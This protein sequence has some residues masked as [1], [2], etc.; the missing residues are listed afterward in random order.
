MDFFTVPTAIF[1]VLYVFVILAHDRRRIVH[2]NVTDS[3]SANWTALQLLHAFP[4]N[5]APR[6]LLRDRDGTYGAEFVRRAKVMGIEE[7]L[8]APRSPWQK[9]DAS[10]YTSFVRFGETS[11]GRLRSESLRPCCLVGAS[12]AGLA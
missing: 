6:F 8:S 1:R 10:H 12:A 4:E 9:A 7:V 2:W 3:P 5:S 11:L